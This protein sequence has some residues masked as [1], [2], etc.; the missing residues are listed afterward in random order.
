[1]VS[2]LNDPTTPSSVKEDFVKALG[3]DIKQEA[4]QSRDEALVKF[5][6]EPK[7]FENIV[8]EKSAK[9]PNKTSFVNKTGGTKM[10]KRRCS[11]ANF[12]KST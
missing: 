1:M 9:K 3:V 12:K 8:K 11:K 4:G 2:M 10:K 7:H 6:F 5:K